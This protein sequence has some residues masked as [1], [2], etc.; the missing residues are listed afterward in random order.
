VSDDLYFLVW[1]S[2]ISHASLLLDDY[3]CLIWSL[4]FAT[5]WIYMFFLALCYDVFRVRVSIFIPRRAWLAE[6]QDQFEKS[7]LYDIIER[8]GA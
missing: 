2:P 7:V 6:R 4:L 1:H 5:E 8:G 3:G